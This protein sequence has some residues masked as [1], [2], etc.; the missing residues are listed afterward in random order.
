MRH[1]ARRMDNLG[2][3]GA[4]GHLRLPWLPWLPGLPGVAEATGRRS[5]EALQPSEPNTFFS[6]SLP[7]PT[8]SLRI[9]FS[10]SPIM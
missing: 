8:G 7:V 9:F 5:P 4:L 3:P 1:A 6:S 2:G 10:S